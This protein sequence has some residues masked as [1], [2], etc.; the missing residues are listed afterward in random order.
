MRTTNT[1]RPGGLFFRVAYCTK[2]ASTN[3]RMAPSKV[4][5]TVSDFCRRLSTATM[6]STYN[7]VGVIQGGIHSATSPRLKEAARGV[8][9]RFADERVLQ[10]ADLGSSQGLNS[11]QPCGDAIAAIRERHQKP[12]SFMIYH[13]DLPTNDFNQLMSTLQSSA[14]YT[15]PDKNPT[16]GVYS[17]AIGKSFYERLFP[18]S[19]LHF[20]MSYITLHWLSN[21]SPLPGISFN[22]IEYGADESVRRAWKEQARKDL[23]NF[24]SLRAAELVS[25]AGLLGVMV[26][27]KQDS[28]TVNPFPSGPRGEKSAIS[29]ALEKMVKERKMTY[30][31]ACGVQVPYYFRTRDEV[32]E[33]LSSPR[34][35]NAFRTEA[36]EEYV[37]S[38]GEGKDLLS[39][40]DGAAE[41]FWGIHENAVRAPLGDRSLEDQDDLVQEL[42]TVF[43]LIL[44]EDYTSGRMSSWPSIDFILL[45]LVRN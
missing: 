29:R 11:M 44:R 16:G 2:K 6:S 22:T 37:I 45:S 27:A 43:R 4:I 10:I 17:C 34:V 26:S 8:G 13:E 39:D 19:Y 25:G 12:A 24:L 9:K 5:A 32:A 1:Q 23:T 31:E 38:L 7:R 28:T 33:V 21:H 3:F 30:Q 20:C 35:R 14:S 41:L 42:K 15:S 18:D 40:V 36:L